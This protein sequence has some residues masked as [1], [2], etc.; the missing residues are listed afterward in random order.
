ML[1]VIVIAK[2]E[3]ATLAR[4]LSSVQFADEIV[5]LDSG[6]DDNTVAI[7]RQYTDK[8]FCTDW[9]GYGVQK[10]RALEKTTG[11]WVLNLDADEWVEPALADAIRSVITDNTHDGWRVPIRMHFQGKAVPHCSSPSRHIRLFRRKDAYF[12]HARVHEKICL[13]KGARIG[14]LHVPI[15]HISFRDVSHA[16]AKMNRY[17]SS[18]AAIRREKGRRASMLRTIGGTVW[19]FFRC[20]V[21]QGGF[22]DGRTGFLF[23]VL[24][25]QGTFYRGIKQFYP[26]MDTL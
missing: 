20:Y 5:V 7:A 18:T 12:S 9:Q 21:V 11:E 4:C 24:S 22:L 2:N 19:M 10:Q 26:D 1:S 23:A 8:V 6:S 16:I 17:S 3:E 13:P 25:A 14:Q 15:E